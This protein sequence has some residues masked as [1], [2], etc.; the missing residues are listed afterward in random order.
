MLTTFLARGIFSIHQI[1]KK[2][3]KRPEPKKI[4]YPKISYVMS[5]DHAKEFLKSIL[6]V[7]TFLPECHIA[8]TTGCEK[9]IG[10]PYGFNSTNVTYF[11]FSRRFF[12]IFFVLTQNKPFKSTWVWPYVPM[13]IITTQKQQ[14][15]GIF[16]GKL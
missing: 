13:Y 9:S 11:I 16:E 7:K 2:V 1:Q 15:P 3:K 5:V 10:P 4:L 14:N 12:A 8:P 6:Y